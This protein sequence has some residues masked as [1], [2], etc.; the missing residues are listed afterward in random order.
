MLMGRVILYWASPESKADNRDQTKV[1]RVG[2]QQTHQSQRKRKLKTKEAESNCFT[3]Y[4]T[5]WKRRKHL[6]YMAQSSISTNFCVKSCT[7][8]NTS[9]RFS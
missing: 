4:K 8:R 6:L 9:N 5:N 1:P 7:K 2:I 3:N